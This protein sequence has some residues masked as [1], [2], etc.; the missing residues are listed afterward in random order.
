M[1]AI[2]TKVHGSKQM[3][4]S[5]A[6]E[7]D[8]LKSKYRAGDLERYSGKITL[9]IQTEVSMREAAKQQNPQTLLTKSHCNC[10]SDCTTKR[11]PCLAKSI[12]CSTHCHRSSPCK[13]NIIY[14]LCPAQG[15]MV[16]CSKCKPNGF[17]EV[18]LA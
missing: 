12:N 17:M 10:V 15:F 9:N 5:L 8:R 3:S 1:P 13:N 2:V 16:E 14:C 11:C 7:Y 4:Y 18:A 6:T